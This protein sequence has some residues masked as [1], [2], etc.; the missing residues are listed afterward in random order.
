MELTVQPLFDSAPASFALLLHVQRNGD[1]GSPR[2]S[3]STNCSSASLDA[4]LSLLDARSPRA[5]SSHS[6][7]HLHAVLNLSATVTNRLADA[8]LDRLV[9]NA[10]K[11]ELKGESMRKRKKK[12]TQTDQSES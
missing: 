6:P 3:G 8:I 7:R 12:L 2:A 9:H 4:R 11:L 10:Y 5:G 1:V